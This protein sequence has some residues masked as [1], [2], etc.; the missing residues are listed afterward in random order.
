MLPSQ[1]TPQVYFR[2]TVTDCPSSTQAH[3]DSITSITIY[4]D[5]KAAID[6]I[7]GITNR[8]QSA[9]SWLKHKNASILTRIQN[10]LPSSNLLDSVLRKVKGHSQNYWNDLNKLPT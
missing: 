3:L 1:T 10:I 2:C 5:S 6:V 8:N 4:I 7:H 9:R